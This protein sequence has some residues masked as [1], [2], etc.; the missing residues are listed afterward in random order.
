MKTSGSLLRINQI[1][2]EEFGPPCTQIEPRAEDRTSRYHISFCEL[3]GLLPVVCTGD[4]Q[5]AGAG[6]GERS[7]VPTTHIERCT[8]HVE[9]N[10]N[11][12]RAQ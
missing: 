5:E 12:S 4:S 9:R 3:V 11:P 7:Q 10:Q 2:R 1:R 6:S 8:L